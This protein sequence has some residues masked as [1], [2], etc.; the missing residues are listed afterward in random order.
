MRI[1]VNISYRRGHRSLLPPFEF[2]QT[3]I[4]KAFG[5]GIE[6]KDVLVQAHE[7]DPRESSENM[8]YMSVDITADEA[9]QWVRDHRGITKEIVDAVK[10]RT[11]EKGSTVAVNV[12]LAHICVEQITV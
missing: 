6:P 5:R 9:D 12:V 10:E 3:T 4:A 1:F 8:P 11:L 2:T 7:Y